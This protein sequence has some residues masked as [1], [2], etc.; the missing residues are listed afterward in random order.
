MGVYVC[1]TA[2]AML[3]G[4]LAQDARAVAGCFGQASTRG[5]MLR[6]GYALFGA[7]SFLPL[8]LVAA[9]RYK[10][11]TDWFLYLEGFKRIAAR[12][13]E[14]RDPLFNVLNLVV[15]WLGGN[16]TVFLA[17]CALIIYGFVFAAIYRGS[18]SVP[19][20]IF[21]YVGSGNYFNSMSQLRQEMA[22]AVFLFA[23]T[24]LRRRKMWAYFFWILVA[25]LLHITAIAYF[26]LYFLYG[27]RARPRVHMLLF[28]GAV[29]VMPVANR[30]LVWLLSYSIFAHYF[31]SDFN[32]ERI[33]IFGFVVALACCALLDYYAQF[34]AEPDDGAG[35]TNGEGNGAINGDGGWDRDYAFYANCAF[36]GLLF[37][38]YSGT[39]PQITRAAALFT[40]TECLAFPLM[41]AR[42]KRRA[43]RVV[44]CLLLF[45]IFIANALYDTY[46]NKWFTNV[47]YHVVIGQDP[48]DPV[49]PDYFEDPGGGVAEAGGR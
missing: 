6:L 3:F 33:Y 27:L 28:A 17:V 36:L 49:V 11:G 32:P 15:Y 38:L 42:E 43:R 25:T 12:E 48:Q 31:D 30:V 4:K 5:A 41:L 1:M 9:L 23:L 16:Y 2:A 46:H 35:D 22:M 37:I 19:V 24:Y 47:P 44:A 20:A 10:V 8:F 29:V 34:G 7:L 21:I 14:F 40:V 18:V 26:P 45:S 39:V 13:A